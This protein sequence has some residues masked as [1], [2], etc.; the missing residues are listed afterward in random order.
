MSTS[1]SAPR[2]P[3]RPSDA[4]RLHEPPAQVEVPEALVHDLWR[5]QRFDREALTTTEDTAVQILDPGT[6]NS[7]AG[8]DF[9]GAHLRLGSMDW[10]G[11]IEIHTASGGWFEHDHHTDPRYNR[12]ILHIALRADLWTGGLLRED[13]SPLPELVLAPQLDTPLRDLLH[14]F[15]TRPDDDSLPCAPRWTEVPAAT[16][17][18]WMHRL[19]RERLQA[20][21]DALNTETST[22]A[23]LQERLFAGLGYAK[24]DGPMSQVARRV[25]P[26]WLRTLDTP[27][28]REALLL[29]TAGLIPAPEDLLEA[30]RPTADYAMALRDRFR[31][32]QVSYEIP[33]LNETAWT[34]FRLRPNNF[35]PLRLAQ[36]AAWYAEDAVLATNPL[37]RLRSA[38]QSDTPAATLRGA[39]AADP[40]SFWRTHYH[41]TKRSA[42]H[43]PSLG[44]SRRNTLLVNAVAPILLLDAQ[45]RD[46]PDQA[47]TV[48]EM[49]RTLPAPKDNVTRRFADLGTEAQSAFEAQGMHRLYREYCTAGGCLDCAIGQHLLDRTPA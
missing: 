43:D 17:R 23:A 32:L 18:D 2:Y 41:P 28:A 33:V 35:P 44:P 7:D 25:D 29:G 39:L 31:R 30:D 14:A 12:V 24:N 4:L 26:D 16:T 22:A 38:L 36:A 9:S 42:E 49:L 47:E 46:D 11:D 13:G 19:A 48:F 10:R 8:P 5:T 6:P 21:R 34:F 1:T 45:H 27:R 40:P 20:K 3:L 37:P 15:R